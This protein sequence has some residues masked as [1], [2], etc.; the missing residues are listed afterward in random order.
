MVGK[1]TYTRPRNRV[2]L[3]LDPYTLDRLEA[4]ATARKIDRDRAAYELLQQALGMEPPPGLPARDA[5]PE[6]EERKID[7][8]KFQS[9]KPS[10]NQN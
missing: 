5:A 7:F 9:F 8:A 2:Q 6:I 1:R 4:V 3:D 10:N